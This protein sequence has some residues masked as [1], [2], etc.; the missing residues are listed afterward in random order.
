ME[1]NWLL[2]A[3]EV[4][5]E[6]VGGVTEQAVQSVPAVQQGVHGVIAAGVALVR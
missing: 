5:D 3:F 2:M 1:R 4:G 6:G